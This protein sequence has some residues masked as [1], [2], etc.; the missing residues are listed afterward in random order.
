[1]FLMLMDGMA[2]AFLTNTYIAFFFQEKFN[3]KNY[4]E[5]GIYLL[6]INILKGSGDFLSH[7]LTNRIGT[8][9]SMLLLYLSSSALLIILP[10]T[11]NFA[12]TIT[13]FFTFYAFSK[14]DRPAK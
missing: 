4:V 12:V 3:Y 11:N 14:I 6:F 9:K 5:I 10:F 1:M 8:I 7:K 13:I 2:A